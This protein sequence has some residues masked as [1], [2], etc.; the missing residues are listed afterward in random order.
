M[1]TPRVF[2]IEAFHRQRERRAATLT[3]DAFLLDEINAR[4]LD[5][6]GDIKRRFERI[7]DLGARHGPLA[8]ALAERNP[9]ARIVAADPAPALA[10]RAPPPQVVS[11]LELL[12]FADQSFDAVVSSA[13][14]HV[15]N[16]LPGALVQARRALVPDGL[17]LI[18]LPG[19][20]T[21][22]ELRRAFMLA[23]AELTGGASPRVAPFVDVRDL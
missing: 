2:D 11:A 8:R 7:L 17:L 13:S 19:G 14:L 23:E 1:A 21:L 22:V 4:L 20:D 5:R 16:D 3:A 10:R 18:A 15:V 6:M 12:P 9:G